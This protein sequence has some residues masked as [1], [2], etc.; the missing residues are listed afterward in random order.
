MIFFNPS[1]APELA[2]N[3]CGCRWFDRMAHRCYECGAEVPDAA[4]AEAPGAVLQSVRIGVRRGELPE[5]L[6]DYVLSPVTAEDEPAFREAVG[7][8]ADAVECLLREGAAA[9]ITTLPTGPMPPAS[10]NTSSAADADSACANAMRRRNFPR[11]W[12]RA[13]TSCPG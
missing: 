1:G 2:C 13:T 10:L 4:R 11:Y 6:A 9:A 3:E 8:A 7:R 5:E 12:L